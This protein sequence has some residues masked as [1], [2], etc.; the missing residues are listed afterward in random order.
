MFFTLQ[1]LFDVIIMTI[2][3]G[4]IFSSS[5]GIRPQIKSY[6]EDPVSYYQSYL[7][8]KVSGFQLQNLWTSMLIAVPAVLFHELAH[9]L[10]ALYYGLSATFHA[11]YFWLGFGVL[12]KVLNTG[13]IFFVPAYVQHSGAAL[14]IQNAAIAF[15]G[16]AING[17][18]WVTCFILLKLKLKF[19]IR[20]I[21]IIAASK[22]ING[23][24]FIFNLI[25][26]GPFDGAQVLNGILQTYF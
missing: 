19:S 20:T 14:P 6:E 12:M 3:V 5:F 15:A 22:Y 25:P 8:R 18:L 1:E 10:M 9:K 2:A 26:L 24:L 16:P 21:Q 13:F 17:I 7:K 11:A 23:F 4:Y